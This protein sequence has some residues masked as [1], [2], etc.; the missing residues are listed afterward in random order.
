MLR[1]LGNQPAASRLYLGHDIRVF[2]LRR[3]GA[4]IHSRLNW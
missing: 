1:T 2:W 4:F 3:C